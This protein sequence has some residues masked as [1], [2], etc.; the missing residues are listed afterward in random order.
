MKEN[1]IKLSITIILEESIKA[2][3]NPNRVLQDCSF[4]DVVIDQIDIF[5]P[6]YNAINMPFILLFYPYFVMDKIAKYIQGRK[7]R[8][9]LYGQ[10]QR[11]Y[12]SISILFKQEN[13]S[14]ERLEY[15]N[16]MKSVLERSIQYLESN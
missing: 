7:I 3:E 13:Q 2:I 8:K 11:L 14:K 6:D 10:C 5:I 9:L 15:L 4:G 16:Y 12:G 1:R